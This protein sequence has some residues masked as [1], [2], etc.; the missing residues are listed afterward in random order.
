M[1]ST[2]IARWSVAKDMAAL[3]I[4]DGY[5]LEAEEA[6]YPLAFTHSNA[7]EILAVLAVRP[8][9][10]SLDDFLSY[11]KSLLEKDIPGFIN[12]VTHSANTAMSSGALDGAA[13]LYRSSWEAGPIG[14]DPNV[15]RINATNALVL[16]DLS[17]HKDLEEAYFNEYLF[18]NDAEMVATDI[19]LVFSSFHK[20]LR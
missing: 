4:E 3:I 2:G 8:D 18:P 5:I 13:L 20:P 17:R 14:V 1:Q 19:R 9:E 6:L 16:G 12:I 7:K 10:K 11:L 15:R